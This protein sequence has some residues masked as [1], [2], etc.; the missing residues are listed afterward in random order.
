MEISILDC[1]Y[2]CHDFPSVS[3]I[4]IT[5]HFTAGET[6][7]I[8]YVQVDD[9]VLVN[10]VI[11]CQVEGE[12]VPDFSAHGDPGLGLET[13]TWTS[14]VGGE[15]GPFDPASAKVDDVLA[16]VANVSEEEKARVIDAE[17]KG[18]NRK[19]LLEK[20]EG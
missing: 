6:R 8:R 2:V 20:L 17:K 5:V 3:G 4:L 9:L 16:Y 10:R 14:P 11:I 18:K 13:S 7:S 15:A 1:L 19:T 12:T